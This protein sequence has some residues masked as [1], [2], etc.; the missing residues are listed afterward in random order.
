MSTEIYVNRF[1]HGEAARFPAGELERSFAG[2]V[3]KTEADM[4]LLKLGDSE[5]VF[6]TLQARGGSLETDSFTVSRPVDD[7]RLY[8]ALLMVLQNEGSVAYAPG[9]PLVVAIAV[10]KD[11]LPEDMTEALGGSV[12]ASSASGL[13]EALFGG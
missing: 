13:R 4:L 6:V 2:V 3:A 8:E 1:R 7:V 12:K 11:H 5:E 9:S 10:S